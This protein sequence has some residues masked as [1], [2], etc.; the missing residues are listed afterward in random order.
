[1]IKFLKVSA[2]LYN[3]PEKYCCIVGFSLF[4]DEKKL[5]DD[6]VKH[7]GLQQNSNHSNSGSSEY[8]ITVLPYNEV[9]TRLRDIADATDK[10]TWVSKCPELSY[11]SLT[12]HKSKNEIFSPMC[13]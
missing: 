6:A 11:F 1:M 4:T 3:W 10:K 12:F 7:L 13:I 8:S 2:G 9:I 5:S